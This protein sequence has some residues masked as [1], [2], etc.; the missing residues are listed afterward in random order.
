MEVTAKESGHGSSWLDKE[1]NLFEHSGQAPSPSKDFCQIIVG[2]NQVSNQFEFS[3]IS[4]D[5]QL[6]VYTQPRESKTHMS[7]IW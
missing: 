2:S 6:Y 5:K 7:D 3:S 1:G 4:H